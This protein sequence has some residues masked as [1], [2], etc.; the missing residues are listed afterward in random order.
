[1]KRG[2]VHSL[3]G[4]LALATFFGSVFLGTVF[5]VTACSREVGVPADSES[6]QHLASLPQDPA[7]SFLA[8][9]VDAPARVAHAGLRRIEVRS[10]VDGEPTSLV[11]HERITADG[12][13]R[14]AIEPV[15][16][17]APSM[18]NLQREVFEVLQRARQGFFFKYR[19]LRVRDVDLFLANYAVNVVAEPVVVAG[20]ECLEIE[21]TPRFGPRRSYRLAVDTSTGLILRS[22]ERDATGAVVATATFLEF[23]LTPEEQDVEFYAERYPGTPLADATLPPGFVPARPQILPEGYR[24]VSSDVVE[25]E[26]Q[27]YV[28]RVYGDGFENLFFLERREPGPEATWVGGNPPTVTVRIAEVGSFRVAEALRGRGSFFVVGK[29]SEGDVLAILRSAL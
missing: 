20:V 28:R 6:A 5:F 26:G 18:T 8:A 9:M 2:A 24:E 11:Y 21:V 14:Y 22:L 25:L 4:G 13:G 12:T 27:T 19:D 10:T 1:M 23:T 16:V 3:A 29:V 7:P 15:S 17:T